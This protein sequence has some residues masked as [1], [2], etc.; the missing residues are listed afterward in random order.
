MYSSRSW[1]GFR[2]VRQ[3]AKILAFTIA[4][5]CS[6]A[7]MWW[8]IL[9]RR[10][11]Y[12]PAL[13]LFAVAVFTQRLLLWWAGP[14]RREGFT[15]VPRSVRRAVTQKFRERLARLPLSVRLR[16]RLTLFLSFQLLL[17]PSLLLSLVVVACFHES[18]PLGVGVFAFLTVVCFAVC[19][20]TDIR[21]GLNRLPILQ[22]PTY[23]WALREPTII[24]SDDF[25]DD[26]PPEPDAGVRARLSPRGP[27]RSPGDSKQLPHSDL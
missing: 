12:V 18:V 5:I 17:I 8:V 25:P 15:R 10:H 24:A 21:R 13:L 26:T 7:P 14:G 20:T 22:R 3:E 1:N 6:L 9:Y 19:C 27:S 11:P 23:S 2:S 16:L 4:S